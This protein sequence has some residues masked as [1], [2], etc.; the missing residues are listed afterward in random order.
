VDIFV[1]NL[2]KDLTEDELRAVFERYGTV[3]SV[4][5]VRDKASGRQMGFGFVDMPSRDEAITAINA[6]KGTA[7]RGRTLEFHDSRTRFE[8]RREADRRRAPRDGLDRRKR[9]RRRACRGPGCEKPPS[10]DDPEKR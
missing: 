6:L 1:R 3:A 9:E 10:P 5:I 2:A 7:V 8:R 4:T